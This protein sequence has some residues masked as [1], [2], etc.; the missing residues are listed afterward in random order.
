L[1]GDLQYLS[2]LFRNDARA[3]HFKHAVKDIELRE[4]LKRIRLHLTHLKTGNVAAQKKLVQMASS[5][6]NLLNP[7]M[8]VKEVLNELIEVMN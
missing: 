8:R 6:L 5:E 4:D 1:Q 2:S 7:R 3:L